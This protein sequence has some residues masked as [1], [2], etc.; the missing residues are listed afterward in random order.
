[1][2]CRLRFDGARLRSRL[3]EVLAL[4][5][6]RFPERFPNGL[7]SELLELSVDVFISECVTTIGADGTHEV[8]ARL[9]LW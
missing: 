5:N 4:A 6:I 1:M 8:S 2:Q 7:L 3:D 9:D